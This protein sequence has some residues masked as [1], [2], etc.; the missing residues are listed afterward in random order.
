[1]PLLKDVAVFLMP[2][3]SFWPYFAGTVL[4]IIGL[5][6]AVRNDLP[7][8]R[9]I[10]RAAVFGPLFFAL[11][12]GVFGAYHFAFSRLVA[13]V[14]PSWMPGHLFWTY[15]VGSALIAAALSITLN[16]HSVLA[17]TLLSVMLFMF[18]LLI[19]VPRLVAEPS[20]RFALAVLLRDLSFSGGAL[21]CAVA[22]A[23]DWPKG[24]RNGITVLVRY[25]IAVPAFFFGVEHFLHPQYVPVIPLDR[26]MPS[27]TPA[28]WLI[29]YITGAVLIAASLSIGFNWKARVAATWL[30]I[31]VFL[32]VMIV[33]LPILVASL[34]DIATG[35]NYFVDTLAFAGGVFLL[36]GALPALDKA[37]VPSDD[38]DRAGF[39][40]I[41]QGGEI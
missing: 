1:M 9:G 26:L 35:L 28:Q 19:H 32:D 4:L 5:A 23:E 36:A 18:V 31:V 3:R 14:V 40:S 30:G 2:G 17:A 22:R 8:A 10:D 21:A 29:S 16:K 20:S 27:G 39:V 34:S 12:M 41:Q 13:T 24:L 11:P 33:Y 37:V 15:L 6:Q 25:M 7:Q 38:E